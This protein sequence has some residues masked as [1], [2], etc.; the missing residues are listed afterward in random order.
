MKCDLNICLACF[1][2]GSEFLNHKSDHDYK[3]LDTKFVLFEPSD[4][5]AEEELTLLDAILNYGNWN[6]VAQEFPNRTAD[7]VEDH[8]E[9]FYLR[10]KG[11]PNLPH[12]AWGDSAL[13]PP[14]IVPY[15]FS[16]LDSDEPPRYLSNT[17]GYKSL[18]GYN[19]A[20]SEFENEYNKNA[21]D[22]LANLETIDEDDPKYALLTK[23][24]CALVGTYNRKLKERQRWKNI[25]SHHGLLL[26]R[27]T[28]SWLHRYDLTVEK[29]VYEKLI[30]FMQFCEPLKFD[31]LIE[32]LHRIG[33]LKIH[34]SRYYFLVITI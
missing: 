22:I 28:I 24:Q 2:N 23:L 21:E 18:A 33:E 5:T 3:I 19:P 30:R 10:K 17:I 7:E 16:L 4:W 11:H 1:C 32:G 20:R 25:L 12:M 26:L 34:I 15:R 13:C 8:Y 14:I 27:K 6:L 9:Y 29:N 31:M